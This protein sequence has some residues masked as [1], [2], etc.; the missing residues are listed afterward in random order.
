M[1]SHAKKFQSAL[2]HVSK[3]GPGAC[4]APGSATKQ[5]PKKTDTR[6]SPAPGQATGEHG[7]GQT[8][9]PAL[10]QPPPPSEGSGPA[11]DE[12]GA[13]TKKQESSAVS[14]EELAAS[15]VSDTAS[16]TKVRT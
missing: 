13:N 10:P 6:V 5:T 8:V 14:T 1:H 11:R 12:A 16:Q 9:D 3:Q 7:G 2:G 4:V 15:A